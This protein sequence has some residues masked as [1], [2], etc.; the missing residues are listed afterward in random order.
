MF[1]A[2]VNLRTNTRIRPH[3]ILQAYQAIK[4]RPPIT[5]ITF[6]ITSNSNNS[7]P[8]V[9][10]STVSKALICKTN[11]IRSKVNSRNTT[12]SNSIMNKTRTLKTTLSPKIMAKSIR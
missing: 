1:Q 2:R 10:N 8:T 11:N 5:R 3:K 9:S 7:I 6:K 4:E 12:T